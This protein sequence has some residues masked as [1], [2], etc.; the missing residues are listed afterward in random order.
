M[1]VFGIWAVIVLTLI[2][3]K[4]AAGENNYDAE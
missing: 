2:L 3:W 1:N 4:L